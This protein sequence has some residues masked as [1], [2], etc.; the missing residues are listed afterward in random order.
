MKARRARR[1]PQNP[2]PTPSRNELNGE[3]SQW[4]NETVMMTKTQCLSNSNF[5]LSE[6]NNEA[7]DSNKPRVSKEKRY[8]LG[9][10]QVW[11]YRRK[12]CLL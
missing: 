9:V 6:G 4:E 1:R 8:S 11:K 10:P 12:S 3:A 7:S 2:L 5:N